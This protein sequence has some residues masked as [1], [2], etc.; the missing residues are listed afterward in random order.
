MQMLEA[1]VVVSVILILVITVPLVIVFR[2][3]FASRRDVLVGPDGGFV[4]ELGAADE[5]EV[6]LRIGADEESETPR[7]VAVSGTT[8][9]G[10]TEEAFEV[11]GLLSAS[12]QE[13]LR[14]V[15]VRRGPARIE[16]R[17]TLEG[18]ARFEGGWVYFRP[19]LEVHKR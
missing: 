7:S 18:S 19:S 11:H 12:G 5:G 3:V 2:R 15:V 16:G 1:A 14:L 6:Y 10:G 8:H 4:L 17:I 9:V 13:S